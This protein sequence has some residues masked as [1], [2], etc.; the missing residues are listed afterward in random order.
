MELAQVQNIGKE[1]LID[2]L[3]IEIWQTFESFCWGELKN[4]PPSDLFCIANRPVLKGIS[5]NADLP[6][7]NTYREWICWD[8]LNL[9][10]GGSPHPFFLPQRRGCSEI[11]FV[12]TTFWMV[13]FSIFKTSCST[14]ENCSFDT[15]FKFGIFSWNGRLTNGILYPFTID[16]ISWPW[17][18]FFSGCYEVSWSSW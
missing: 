1:I 6:F 16:N 9:S 12:C 7:W 3:T 14:Y 4:M 17:V 5:S 15:F 13:P 11:A 2:C 18:I 10:L 8:F